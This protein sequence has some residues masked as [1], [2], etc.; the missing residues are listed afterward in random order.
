MSILIWSGRK[1]VEHGRAGPVP[2]KGDRVS[3]LIDFPEWASISIVIHFVPTIGGSND[4]TWN[5]DGRACA[6]AA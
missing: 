3:S 5:C 4:A 1:S 2:G 6:F